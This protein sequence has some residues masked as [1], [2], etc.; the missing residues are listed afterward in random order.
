VGNTMPRIGR[1]LV[2]LIGLRKSDTKDDADLMHLSSEGDYG[3]DC[4]A[5]QGRFW[6]PDCGQERKDLIGSM[7]RV[8]IPK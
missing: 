1:G 8:E 4:I 3:V 7:T 5:E 2:C 6:V